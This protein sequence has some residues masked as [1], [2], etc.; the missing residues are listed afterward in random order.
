MDF[1]MVSTTIDSA[2]TN[3]KTHVKFEVEYDGEKR[4][5]SD[6]M[7]ACLKRAMD[8]G[9]PILDGKFLAALTRPQM[10]K[11]F[12]GN[13][14]MP[15]LDEKL[16]NFRDV[17]KVL[18]ERYDGYFPQFH[19]LVPAASSTTTATAWSIAWSKNSRDLTTS[20][21]YDGHEIK[22][23]KLAQLGY[24]GIYSGLRATNTLA[25]SDIG[26]MTA[27]ADYIVP[28]GLRL[29]GITSY[30]PGLEHAIDYLP[31]HPARLH[32]GNRNP[33][34]LAVRHRTARG[35]NQQNPPRRPGN[36]HSAD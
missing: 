15:M 8:S 34:A 3:F 31:T 30:S 2:F 28:V 27:F 22:F 23:Y 9:I 16:Q 7:V 25:L 11:I 13:I 10:E 1:I 6:A 29:I 5:D 4:S 20:A 33:R 14:E 26:K 19:Q 32:P 36:H 18:A 12:A 17:G 35:R 21:E 24:W